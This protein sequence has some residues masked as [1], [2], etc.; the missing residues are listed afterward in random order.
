MFG[1]GRA[2]QYKQLV[3]AQPVRALHFQQDVQCFLQVTLFFIRVEGDDVGVEHDA[4]RPAQPDRLQKQLAV[5]GSVEHMLVDALATGL[6]GNTARDQSRLFEHRQDLIDVSSRVQ[7]RAEGQADLFA[8][9]RSE[10]L[11]PLIVN[12]EDLVFEHDFGG[13]MFLLRRGQFS[14][15]VARGSTAQKLLAGINVLQ[16]HLAAISAAVRAAS[17]CD[18]LVNSLQAI[19]Q[20]RV[21]LDQPVVFDEILVLRSI[22]APGQR[23][24]VVYQGRTRDCHGGATAPVAEIGYAIQAFPGIQ[25]PGD[26]EHC[27]VALANTGVIAILQAISRVHRRII[28]APDHGRFG[29]GLDEPRDPRIPLA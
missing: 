9:Q 4:Q 3:D 28:P 15:R 11:K 20:E 29:K 1:K 23:V 7:V 10:L 27:D 14:D 19:R 25:A 24:E 2:R 8:I 13:P 21:G 16:R 17:G 26:L 18:G 12:P 5:V 22:V 6:Q